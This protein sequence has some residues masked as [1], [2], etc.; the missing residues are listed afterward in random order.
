LLRYGAEALVVQILRA[1]L[2]ALLI[3][4]PL[5]APLAVIPGLA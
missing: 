1:A 5:G 3:P 4:R 2:D